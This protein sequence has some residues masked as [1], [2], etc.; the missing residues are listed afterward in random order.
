MVSWK[1]SEVFLCE[2][3]DCAAA[4]KQVSAYSREEKS[5]IGYKTEKVPARLL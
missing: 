3:I 5:Y 1:I 2:N 4:K